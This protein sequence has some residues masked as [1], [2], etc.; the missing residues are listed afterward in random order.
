MTSIWS[1]EV[2]DKWWEDSETKKLIDFMEWETIYDVDPYV[3]LES[4]LFE[5]LSD[6]LNEDQLSKTEKILVEYSKLKDK[7]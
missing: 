2:F 7:E 3:T 5:K 4:K 6:F 1:K